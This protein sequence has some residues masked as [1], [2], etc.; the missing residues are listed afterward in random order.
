PASFDAVAAAPQRDAEQPKWTRPQ[1]DDRLNAVPQTASLLA[2]ADTI[3]PRAPLHDTVSFEP[4][5]I[6]K[7]D[8]DFNLDQP[9]RAGISSLPASKSRP[10]SSALEEA[11][12]AMAAPGA[13][14]P[15][16]ARPAAAIEL[17][18]LDLAFDPQRS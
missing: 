16:L 17:D 14:A 8:L 11:A 13:A 15:Q 2:N 7:F 12:V 6:P 10:L 9:S 5:S 3:D 4:E 1:P 18:K